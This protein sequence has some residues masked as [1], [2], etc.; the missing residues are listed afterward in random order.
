MA[1]P[2]SLFL[3]PLDGRH[4]TAPVPLPKQ[5]GLGHAN[6]NL[7]EYVRTLPPAAPTRSEDGLLPRRLADHESIGFRAKLTIP[8]LAQEAEG[9]PWMSPDG[10][11][12][13]EAASWTSRPRGNQAYFNSKALKVTRMALLVSTGGLCAGLVI[14]LRD[15]QWAAGLPWQPAPASSMVELPARGVPLRSKAMDPA[16][17]FILEDPSEIES[18]AHRP[19]LPPMAQS[20]TRTVPM[21]GG[22]VISK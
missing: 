20:E 2:S 21:A 16:D 3:P 12:R 1:P 5:L 4:E 22:P 11:V 10:A 18:F 13:N 7:P 19:A 8:P 6:F 9:P 17:L 15:R 14:F